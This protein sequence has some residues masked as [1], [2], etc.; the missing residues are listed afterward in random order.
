MSTD[1]GVLE[2]P[3]PYHISLNF[4]D[5]VDANLQEVIDK[6]HG[7]A[8]VLQIDHISAGAFDVFIAFAVVDTTASASCDC[9]CC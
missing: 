2:A 9:R 4:Q 6:W 3:H 5:S 7:R 8:H 1:V